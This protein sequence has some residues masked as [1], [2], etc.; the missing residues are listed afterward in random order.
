MSFQSQGYLAIAL[1]SA[2]AF[3]MSMFSV[4][5]VEAKTALQLRTL[6]TVEQ[7]PLLTQGRAAQVEA[8]ITD[9]ETAQLYI[10]GLRQDRVIWRSLVPWDAEKGLLNPA[11]TYI[12]CDAQ[13]LIVASQYPFSAATHI[14]TFSWDGKAFA[15][16]T[17]RNEDLSQ[18][19]LDAAIAAVA[20]GQVADITT[21]ELNGVFYPHRYIYG[22]YGA[23]ENAI[24]QG[25]K[26]A[27]ELHRQ[28][29][30]VKARERLYRIFE[31]TR[32]F[33]ALMG[34]SG[35]DQPTPQSW[36]QV[37]HKFRAENEPLPESYVAALND[38]G[39]FLQVT[40]KQKAA[41]PVLQAVVN[42]NPQR[43]PAHLNLADALWVTQQ[44]TKARQHYQLYQRLMLEGNQGD[45]IPD[46]VSDRLQR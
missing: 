41:I 16:Q 46:Y 32:R 36:L 45:R 5:R 18:E 4:S 38:Y 2:L 14:Q 3:P 27:L 8:Q 15:F 33:G 30:T 25:H 20:S 1:C 12:S 13:S 21:I 31:L 44:T 9:S 42:E 11:K 24:D 22:R 7:C 37:W 43:T 29:N 39:Y 23:I 17:A 34:E 28:G 10:A 26:T 19:T 35:A 6:Q 40:G